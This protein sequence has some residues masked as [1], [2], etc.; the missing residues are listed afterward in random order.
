[1][2]I[3]NKQNVHLHQILSEQVQKIAQ[4]KR[5]NDELRTA[6]GS[7]LS[8]TQPNISRGNWYQVP[9]VRQQFDNPQEYEKDDESHGNYYYIV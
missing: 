9:T 7:D 5:D 8:R 6:K 1:M 2:Q 3:L 4:L